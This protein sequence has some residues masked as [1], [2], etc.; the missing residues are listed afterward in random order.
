MRLVA[1]SGLWSTGPLV[2]PTPLVRCSKSAAPCCPGLSTI[3][4]RRCGRSRSPT[5]LSA[6]W[7]WRVLGESGHVALAAAL[8]GRR[9][10]RRRPSKLAGVDVQP[11]SVD[12]LRRLAIGHWLRRWWPASHRDGIA[13]LDRCAAR[14]RDRAADRGRA[15]TSSP[16]TRSIPMWRG[17]CRRMRRHSAH[18]SGAEI[19]GV[20][21][22]VRAASELTDDVGIALAEPAEAMPRRDDFALA[23]G[24]DGPPE[25]RW[26]GGD[27]EQAHST[28]PGV[29]PG[30]FDAAENTIEWRVVA[31]DAATNAVVGVALSG[32]ASPGGVAVRLRSRDFSGAGILDG[33]GRAT[34]PIMRRPAAARH[35]IDCVGP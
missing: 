24:L 25:H 31:T 13:A 29:P 14:C 16:T 8:S 6:D 15:R 27:R 19:R 23:A 2:A 35:G 5:R 11:G 17:C 21:E 32:T 18:T 12:E 26:C 30:V 20:V 9:P 1:D 3:A 7:L 10:E 22:L 4:A 34:F 28:G 33:D